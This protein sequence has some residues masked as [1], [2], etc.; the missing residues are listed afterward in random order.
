MKPGQNAP[1]PGQLFLLTVHD[2][3]KKFDNCDII[4]TQVNMALMRKPRQGG[5]R[6][7]EPEAEKMSR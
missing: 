2:W 1:I 5:A 7:S 6:A 4:Y 3:H